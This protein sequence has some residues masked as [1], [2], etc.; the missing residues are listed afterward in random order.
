MN[1]KDDI[2]PQVLVE[3]VDGPGTS[4]EG[5]MNGRILDE[6]PSQIERVASR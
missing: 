2:D 5:E 4:P 1:V 3:S 6:R